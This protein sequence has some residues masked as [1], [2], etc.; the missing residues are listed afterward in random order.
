MAVAAVRSKRVCRLPTV[1]KITGRSSSITNAFFNAIIPVFAPSEAEELE[2]LKILDQSPL[3]VRCAYC[4]D[5][6]SEWDHFF[7]IISGKRP[8]GYVTEIGNLV[9][10]C[11]K[12]NQSKGATHWRE[13]MEGD[14]QL[15]PKTRGIP[16]LRARIRQLEDYERHFSRRKVDFERVAGTASWNQ[17]LANLEAVLA[18]ME[19]SQLLAAQ[20][21]QR[22]AT[23]VV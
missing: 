12:C 11:G 2:A 16:D 4:G 9:P 6:A 19:Q 15:S 23:T 3:D 7:A 22:V 13:W 10:A 14:A 1:I 21:R 5:G 17:H 8:T 20:I 18:A